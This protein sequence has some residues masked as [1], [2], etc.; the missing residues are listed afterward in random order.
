LLHTLWQVLPRAEGW[1]ELVWLSS[2]NISAAL[3]INMHMFGAIV[4]FLQQ[5]PCLP[6]DMVFGCWM[7][8]TSITAPIF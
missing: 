6:W 1:F 8:K 2:S 5:T 7:F 4:L 3:V